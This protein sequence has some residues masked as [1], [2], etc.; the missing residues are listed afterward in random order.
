MVR[1]AL[2]ERA[3]RMLTR[4][5][6][7]RA[8][9]ARRLAPHAESPVGLASLLDELTAAGLLSDER[10]ASSRLAAR[11][12]RYGDARLAYELRS[13]GV[14]DDVSAAALA[15]N[16]DELARANRL[17]QRRFGER[18]EVSASTEQRQR[19]ARFLA[20]RGFSVDTIRRVVGN[21][22]EDE[23]DASARRVPS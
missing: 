20:G 4:R 22:Y 10:Y 19:Q 1:D 16:E 7:A 12:A 3:I 11:A 13:A 23:D 21:T 8:E 17:C 18:M 2:R 15:A 5:E 6:Y 14:A 9:L